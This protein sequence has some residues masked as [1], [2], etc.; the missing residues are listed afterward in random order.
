MPSLKVVFR[1]KPSSAQAD[2]ASPGRAPFGA[3]PTSPGP[4]ASSPCR[5]RL[6][7][8]S[9][10]F[11]EPHTPVCANQAGR[12]CCCEPFHVPF[13]CK[14]PGAERDC[15]AFQLNQDALEREGVSPVITGG[16][17][18]EL[19]LFWAKRF[20]VTRLMTLRRVTCG[21]VVCVSSLGGHSLLRT[22]SPAECPAGTARAGPPTAGFTLVRP[23]HLRMTPKGPGIREIQ[24]FKQSR[25]MHFIYKKKLLSKERY[26]NVFFYN[27]FY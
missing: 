10:R 5:L 1:G 27:Y 16:Q 25:L 19:V 2:P 20:A 12:P 11:A 21:T 22:R 26:L 3:K 4:F 6:Q 17:W 15:I 8:F 18:R 14:L 7:T 13:A 24:S 23:L 9:G